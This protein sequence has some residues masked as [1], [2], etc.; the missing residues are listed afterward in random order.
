[1]DRRAATNNQVYDRVWSRISNQI[2]IPVSAQIINQS[3]EEWSGRWYQVFDCIRNRGTEFTVTQVA[4]RVRQQAKED[5]D[6]SAS[7]S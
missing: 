2:R 3:G 7:R 1:M 5:T 4:D 6:G